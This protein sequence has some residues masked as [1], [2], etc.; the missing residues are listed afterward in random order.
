LVAKQQHYIISDML[1]KVATRFSY[2]SSTV[3][4]F[5]MLC[6]HHIVYLKMLFFSL[7]IF[8]T[9]LCIICGSRLLCK[10]NAFDII[11][12]LTRTPQQTSISFCS[13]FWNKRYS[14]IK[15]MHFYRCL[16]KSH[17]I[18]RLSPLPWVQFKVDLCLKFL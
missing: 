2:C 16:S 9:F 10:E 15:C 8:L 6:L 5:Q 18:W 3:I 17:A 13:N 12:L 11:C 4:E 14:L 1:S 7:L